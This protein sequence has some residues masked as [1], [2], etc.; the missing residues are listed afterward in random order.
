MSSSPSTPTT[1]PVVSVVFLAYNRCDALLVSLREML[2]PGAY[3]QDRLEVIVVDNASSDGTAET[4]A[5]AFPQVRV[6]RNAHNDGAPAWNHGFAVARGDY[7][8]ILDDDAYLR[9]GG[10]ETAVRAARAHAADL[11]SFSVVSSSDEQHRL[12]D[13]WPTGLLSFWGCAALVGAPALRAVEGYDPGIFIW[14]NEVDLTMRLLDHGCRHL[15]LPEVEAVHMKPPIL[16]FE[17]RRYLVNA[18]HHGYIAGKL[19]RPVDA[20]AAVANIIQ[21]AAVDTL[22]EDR[23]AAG[24]VKEAVAGFAAGLRRRRPVRPVVSAAYRHNFHPFIA[25]WRFM[26]TAQDRLRARHDDADAIAERRRRRV[27]SFYDERAQFYPSGEASLQ[28]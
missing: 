3:P 16:E 9:P 7:V 17:P 10:L 5:D 4:V 6:I 13:D 18:R 11:V 23:V 1:L 12:N 28:L 26:R 8:L 22:T 14:A 15:Y 2:D 27:D 19:M 21:R 25:P 24:A 20:L